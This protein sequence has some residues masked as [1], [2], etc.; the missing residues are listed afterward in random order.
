MT[1]QRAIAIGLWPA[2]VGGA[3]AVLGALLAPIV[4][5]SASAP[6]RPTPTPVVEMRSQ[7]GR[8]TLSH[9]VIGHDLFRL[10]RG[11]AAVPYDPDGLAAQVAPAARP[12]LRLLGFVLGPHP[13]A[14]IEGFPGID[15]ARVVRPGDKIGHLTVA[16]I[17]LG[18]V[19]VVGM[20]TV[21]V[22]TVR[23]P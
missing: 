22:L 15:G 18:R 19:R 4:P 21:W 9:V 8:D 16:A 12:A 13:V 5:S 6:P 14:L 7:A 1:S 23:Q 10:G 3:A 17:A 20:D 2:L 11:P